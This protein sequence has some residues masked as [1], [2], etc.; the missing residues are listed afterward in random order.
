[1]Q[2]NIENK[3]ADMELRD[4]NYIMTQ[5]IMNY[6]FFS[7]NEDPEKIVFPMFKEVKHPRKDVMIPVE[8]VAVDSPI[9][10]SISEDGSEVHEATPEEIAA[11]DTRDDM[12]KAMKGEEPT[13]PARASFTEAARERIEEAMPYAGPPIDREP[14]LPPQVIPPGSPLDGMSPRDKADQTRVKKDLAQEPNVDESEEK[15]TEIEKQEE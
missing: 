1:M 13:S 7:K 14:K 11:A 8:W 15:P 2:V 9:A 10:T 6:L 4:W 5:Y 3:S 12:V